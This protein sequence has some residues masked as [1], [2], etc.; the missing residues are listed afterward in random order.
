MVLT[1][2]DLKINQDEYV[3][4]GFLLEFTVDIYRFLKFKIND[5]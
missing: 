5:V 3:D 4:L 2:I 1:F